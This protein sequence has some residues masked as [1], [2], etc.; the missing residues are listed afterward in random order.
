MRWLC[1]V[2]S[3]VAPFATLLH[4]SFR[5]QSA[6]VARLD[7]LTEYDVAA[8]RNPKLSRTTPY[9]FNDYLYI[10]SQSDEEAHR[11]LN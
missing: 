8:L 9:G 5:L 3:E 1:H 4:P 2:C 7:D 6:L 10:V 11:A